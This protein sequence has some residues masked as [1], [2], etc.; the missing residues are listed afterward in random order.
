MADTLFSPEIR[1]ELE[2]EL[3]MLEA[4]IAEAERRGLIPRQGFK[5]FIE[6][7]NPT[8]LNFE[9]IEVLASVANRVIEDELKRVLILLPPRYL[10][11][12]IFSRL[13]PAAYLQRHTERMVGLASYGADLAWELSEEAR[14]NFL[15]DGG[16][17][18]GDTSA[19][20]RWAT[21]AGGEMWAS[22]VGGPLLGRGFHLGIVDDPIDPE[23]AR[24]PMYQRR[25][26]RWW[27]SKFLSRQE[28][29]AAIVFVMQRLGVDDPVDFLLRRE[30]GDGTE[31]APQHWHVVALDEV[32]SDEPLGK[33][34]GPMG[35]PPTCTL[36]PDWRQRGEV[37]APT[38]FT[39]AEVQAKHAETGA[40]DVAAQRQQRPT[41]PTGDF[42]QL[43][44]FQTYDTLPPTAFNR[45]LDWD[46]AFTKDEAN[47][48][49]AYV[50]S[51]RGPGDKHNF[52][53]YIHKVDWDWRK[54]PELVKWMMS[55]TGP[56]YVEA[57]ATG[58]SSVQALEAAGIAA[59]EV[60]VHG[61]KLARASAVQ[62]A[63]S[64]KRIFVHSSVFDNFLR[65]EGQGLLRVTHEQLQTGQGGLDLNDAFVQALHRH[66]EIHPGKKV[67]QVLWV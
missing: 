45:G 55:L 41:M 19:K 37:L 25:F 64:N 15:A 57:K 32:K 47:S 40:M 34:S 43:K 1:E 9:H 56:H 22:G 29:K 11:S 18:R 24:S 54:F 12:E 33:Y 2:H 67:Q 6:R 16:K 42:W 23:K 21:E 27:P 52:P 39:L 26:K 50:E 51:Y 30:V 31:L 35:L 49:S 36:E 13:L 17:M 60:S 8:L 53:I 48:A 4:E 63:V 59:E 3:L 66:L 62:P 46:T 10:K 28:P 65:A 5:A 20:K 14:A 61:D 7:H 38:R 44:W 58:K